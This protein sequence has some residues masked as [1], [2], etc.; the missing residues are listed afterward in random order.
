MPG[1]NAIHWND[2]QDNSGK[3]RCG[4]FLW[5][6]VWREDKADVTCNSCLNLIERDILRQGG[7]QP[8]T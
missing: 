3:A 2:P 1:V 4:R 6:V 8:S 5:T 7:Q